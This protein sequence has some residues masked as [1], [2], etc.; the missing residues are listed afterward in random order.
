MFFM[1][2]H[3]GW[4]GPTRYGYWYSVSRL[5]GHLFG[6]VVIFGTFF[7]FG[8]LLSVLLHYL[9]TLHK[10]PPEILAIITRIEV[11]L[12]YADALLCVIMLMAGTFRFCRDLV[13]GG[14]YG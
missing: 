3:I 1:G 6:T 11:G 12:I 9:D 13:E 7:T 4:R 2:R 14:R 5:I 8:W 10:F